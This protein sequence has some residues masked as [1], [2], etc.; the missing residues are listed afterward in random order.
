MKAVDRGDG[1]IDVAVR[2]DGADPGK[3]RRREPIGRMIV[4][5]KGYSLGWRGRP[6]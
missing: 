6:G 3:H 4:A 5:S 1:A 2:S